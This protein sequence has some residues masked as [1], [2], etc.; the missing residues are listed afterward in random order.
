MRKVIDF[1]DVSTEGLESS[2]YADA[3]AGLRANEARY[4]KNKYAMR[5]SSTSNIVTSSGGDAITM[6]RSSARTLVT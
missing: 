1:V 3:L 2:P 6:S 5:R 4:Y